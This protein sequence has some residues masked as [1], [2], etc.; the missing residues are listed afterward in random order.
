MDTLGEDLVLL[1]IR[2]NG[3][4][5]TKERIGFGLM[6]SELVRLALASRVDIRDDRIVVLD[7]TPTGDPELDQAL[8][9][10]SEKRRPPKATDWVR[11]PRRKILDAY[12]DRLARSGVIRRESARLLPIN[13]WRVAD[14]GR[15]AAA[16]A[17]LDAIAQGSGQV[18]TAQVAL[19]GLA[20]AAG[21]GGLL[22]PGWPHR[23]QRKRLSEVG[24]GKFSAL[25]ADIGVGG[26]GVD[27]TVAGNTGVGNTG[28]GGAGHAATH[29]ANHAAAH[30]ASQA[31]AQ[32]AAHA[33]A[34]AAAHAAAQA[35]A[36]AAASAAAHSASHSGG[37]VG[38]HGH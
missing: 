37:A 36:H 1:S 13:L 9:S 35:A 14:P 28:P 27:R 38:G 20:T 11:S 8:A 10:L 5:A 23:A 24:A 18:D 12:L 26:I 31:A 22:Y 16:R 4:V 15:V 6:G 30:A 19:A 17:R 7:P 3:R 34:Q 32:A 25:R 29:A 33:A 21:L 2:D